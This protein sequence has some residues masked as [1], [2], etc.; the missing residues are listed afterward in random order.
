MGFRLAIA[1]L[2]LLGVTMAGLAAPHSASALSCGPC[3]ATATDDLNLR[4]GP[5]LD[6]DVLRVIPA[7]AELEWDNFQEK[8]NGFVAVSYDGTDGWAHADYLI[9][10]PTF[11]TTTDFLNLR[12]DASLSADVLTVMPPDA[13]VTVLSGPTNGFYSV[14]FD[15]RITG[16]AHGDY[17][18]FDGGST[19]AFT[20][21]DEVVVDTDALNLRAGPGLGEDVE[22]VLYQGA[23]LV[24]LDD[25][26]SADG[27]LWY[28][29]DTYDGTGWVA[30]TYLAA[31]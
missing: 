4:E 12:D 18:D 16:W 24:V 27:Y 22:T 10:Y 23:L 31:A 8:T 28:E 26:E 3:P 13:N 7:G 19:G 25:P 2:A 11:A 15:Q 9:L 17:L 20:T 21:G 1:T 5:S 14:Q 30:G 6:D 29:V